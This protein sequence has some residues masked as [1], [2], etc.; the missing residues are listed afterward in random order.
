MALIDVPLHIR[1]RRLPHDVAQFLQEANDRIRQ[2]IEERQIRISG[3]VPSDFEPVYQALDAIVDNDLA[4]GDVF[5]EWGS[6]FGVVAMLAELLEFQCYGIEIEDSLVTGARQLAREFDLTADFVRGS[7][8]PAGG[9]AI[10]EQLC[11]NEDA[12]LTP[13]TDDA[14]SQLGLSANDFDVIYAFPW[15]GEER[16]IAT[17]FDEFCAVGSLLLTFDHIEGVRARRKVVRR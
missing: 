15:P 14:Y 9:E 3:F 12:W 13:T 10:V 11:A 4:C 16:V 5:C 17:L 6:G 8:I 1:E 7:F 2:F